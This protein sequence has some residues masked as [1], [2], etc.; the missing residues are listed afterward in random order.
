MAGSWNHFTTRKGRF[1][2]SALL[3]NGGDVVEALEECYGMVWYLANE[4]SK[5]PRVD[6]EPDQ[7][8]QEAHEYYTDGLKLSPGYTKSAA[9]QGIGRGWSD[10]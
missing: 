3:E 2:G 5:Q 4:L 9:A 7:L 6:D 8:V 1:R 10:E